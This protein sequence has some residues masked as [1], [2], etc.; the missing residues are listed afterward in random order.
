MEQTFKLRQTGAELQ[1]ILNKCVELPTREELD[2]ELA[3]AYHKPEDGIPNEDLSEGV[4]T[5][6]NKAD[7]ALQE[8][9]EIIN[10]ADLS[11]RAGTYQINSIASI[12]RIWNEGKI[13]IFVAHLTD[14]NVDFVAIL[15]KDSTEHFVGDYFAGSKRFHFFSLAATSQYATASISVSNI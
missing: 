15:K 3:S 8:A 5:S 1:A 13:P 9:Y 10:H 4:R 14:D 7:T 11:L 2:A 12:V 6:L